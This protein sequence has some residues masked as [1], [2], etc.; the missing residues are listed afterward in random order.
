MVEIR[1]HQEFLFL[2]KSYL[3]LKHEVLLM[4]FSPIHPIE[5]IEPAGSTLPWK[6]QSPV[7]RSKEDLKISFPSP[8]TYSP[9]KGDAT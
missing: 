9:P 3:Q 1:D 2:S 7:M 6:R 4:S 5:N 8:L